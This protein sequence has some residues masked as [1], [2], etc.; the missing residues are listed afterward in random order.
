M[1]KVVIAANPF[2]GHV[3]PLLSIAR[4]LVARGHEV[5]VYTGA[6]FE[7][8]ALATGARFR[9]LPPDVDFDDRNIDAYFPAVAAVPPGPA[10]EAL[11]VHQIFVA[12]VPSQLR[13][14]RA[15]LDEFPADVVMSEQTFVTAVALALAAPARQRPVLVTLGIAGPLFLSEDTAPYGTGILPMKGEEGRA[16]NRAMNAEARKMFAETQKSSEETFASIGLTLSEFI[17]NAPVSAAD[18]Y[19]QLTV[20]SFEY[21]RGDAPAHFRCIGPIPQDP[22]GDYDPPAWWPE[23]SGDR[24][25]VVVTQGTLA[26]G[27]L[28]ELVVPT[29]RGLADLDVLVVAA[30]VREDGPDDARRELGEVPANTRL[31]AF[32]PFDRLL[33]RADV[34]VTNGGYGGVHTALHHGVPL[35]V[36]AATEDKP[37]VAARVEWSGTGVNLRTGTPHAADVRAAVQKVLADPN[38]RLRA[39]T[40]GKEFNQ[41]RPFDAIAEIVEA[42]TRPTR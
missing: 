18:H 31:A 23:L 32:V 29:V 21:P 6:R 33:P 36:A 9:A 22:G 20:P 14:L 17:L 27:D 12:P 41:Y 15:L 30:T 35:V 39:E 11:A 13:G 24:P 38:F 7:E 2:H 37:E 5:V 8:R 28:T 34:L 16:R 1:S 42:A 40:L 3:A 25:A 26:N 19:L 4:D 10:R